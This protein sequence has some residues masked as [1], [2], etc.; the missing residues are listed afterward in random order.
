M[1]LINE[2]FNQKIY[3]VKHIHSGVENDYDMYIF[4]GGHY[5]NNIY[6]LKYDCNEDNKDASEGYSFKW[7]PIRSLN[8]NIRNANLSPVKA[9]VKNK[10]K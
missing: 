4:V 7:C 1:T 2:F 5:G 10:K 3:K 9:I 8:K 6:K